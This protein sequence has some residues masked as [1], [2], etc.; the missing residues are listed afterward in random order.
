MKKEIKNCYEEEKAKKEFLIFDRGLSKLTTIN[1]K[2]KESKKKI[3][4]FLLYKILFKNILSS[5]DVIPIDELILRFNIIRSS[6]PRYYK[7]YK[8]NDSNSSAIIKKFTYHICKTKKRNKSLLKIRQKSEDNK[9]DKDKDFN[10]EKK[11]STDSAFKSR[12][13]IK[14]KTVK[15]THKLNFEFLNKDK[16]NKNEPLL[17]KKF[18]GLEVLYENDDFSVEIRKKMNQKI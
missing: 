6:L 3:N 5:K 13:V 8:G 4:W 10:S 16:N 1:Y 15:V 7:G 11:E 18:S 12:S 14:T 9:K 17:S 2:E